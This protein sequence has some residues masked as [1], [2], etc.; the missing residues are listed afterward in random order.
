VVQWQPGRGL[1][2]FTLELNLQLHDTI[3]ELSWVIRWTEE[4]NL[5]WIGNEC[6]PLQPGRL[7]PERAL[8]H[9]RGRG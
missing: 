1:H 4:Q 7:P 3:H 2:S 5:S 6:E 8:L 9:V